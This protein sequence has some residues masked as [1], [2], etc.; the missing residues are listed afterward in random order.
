MMTLNIWPY[1]NLDFLHES[2]AQLFYKILISLT[3]ALFILLISI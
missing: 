1:F 3:K 2:T